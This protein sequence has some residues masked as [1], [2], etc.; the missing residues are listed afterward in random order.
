MR[1]RARLPLIAAI[2]LVP[3]A[4]GMAASANAAVTFTPCPHSTAYTCASVPVPL[5]RSGAVPGTLSLSVARRMA[6][7]A[8]S[9]VA[10]VAL[11]GGPGQAALPLAEYIPQAIAPA[12]GSRDLLV[13]D[14]RGTGTSDPLACAALERIS[15]EPVG[16]VFEQCAHQIGPARGAFTTA[17]SV[18]DI[19]DVRRAAGY[20]KLVLY[21]T[22]YGTKVALEYA[23]RY[24][25]NVEALVLDSVVSPTGWEAFHLSSFAAIRPVLEELCS[26]KACAGVTTNPVGDIALLNARLLRHPLTGSVFDGSGR[27]HASSLSSQGLLGI[28]EAG[29]LNPALRALLPA[30]VRSALAGDAGPLLR[31]QLL[32]EGLIPNLPNEGSGE[33]GESGDVNEILYDPEV[34]AGS[35]RSQQIELRGNREALAFL[36]LGRNAGI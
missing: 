36:V 9:N 35:I 10:V 13:M 16:R 4:A 20:E 17:E 34:P 27:R 33:E 14:Q 18:K 1:L 22:S 7:S 26:A 12:L 8:P 2:A 23:E 28:L 32:A 21:G 30:A 5:D 24:P 29:D 19:E 11:A 25:Q 6:G 31:L 3:S 15:N